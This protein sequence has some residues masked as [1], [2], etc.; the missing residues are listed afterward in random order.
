[1]VRARA[2][3]ALAILL[4]VLV[5]AS[6]VTAQPEPLLPP[7]TFAPIKW[8]RCRSLGKPFAGRLV[9]GTRLPAEGQD[10]F[11]WDPVWERF[12][13]R[14]WRRY[15]CDFAMKKLLR[16]LRRVRTR[17]PEAPRIG[18]G[19]LSRPRGG[20][21]G[22]RYGGLG[23]ASHQSGVDIDIYYPRWDALERP[24]RTVDDIDFELSQALVNALARAGA[25]YVFVGPNT[26]LRG[27]R[28]VVQAL[29]NHDDHLHV[30][31]RVPRSRR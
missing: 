5:G 17:F 18:I 6:S 11:T 27:R 4:A 30:R 29:V 14:S 9:R 26:E 7:T 25:K 31:F 15:G 1:V 20:R 2:S 19:D 23:H 10:F 3:I 22:R 8:K 12:P 24:P 13:N 28:R 21:F 16:V